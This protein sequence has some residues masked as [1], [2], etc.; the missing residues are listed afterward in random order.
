M[1]KH[2]V[3]ILLLTTYG[4][5]VLAQASNDPSVIGL[6]T[7]NTAQPTVNKSAEK[8]YDPTIVGTT[9]TVSS[10][11]V[12]GTIE[13]D[14]S[15]NEIA[16]GT[17]GSNTGNGSAQKVTEVTITKGQAQVINEPFVYREGSKK[18]Q[19]FFTPSN[20]TLQV[21]PAKQAEEKRLQAERLKAHPVSITNTTAEEK[22]TYPVRREAELKT[23][24]QH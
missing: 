21:D 5:V 6:H 7:I 12:T 3:F 2:F 22:A 13:D 20:V 16:A 10:E 4:A 18:G 1:K 24:K 9:T 19:T 8:E 23:A 15:L 17:I 14:P 11:I